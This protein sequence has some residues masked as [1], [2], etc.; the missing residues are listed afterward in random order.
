MA[1][2]SLNVVLEIQKAFLDFFFHF[3]A[4]QPK[5]E[6]AVAFNLSV[7]AILLISATI[8]LPRQC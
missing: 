4:F 6:S 8:P 3:S 7:Y 1:A 2:S 5:P